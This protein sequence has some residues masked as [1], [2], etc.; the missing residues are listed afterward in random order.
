MLLLKDGFLIL[1]IGVLDYISVVNK[2]DGK[3]KIVFN[4]VGM[5][6]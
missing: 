4:G 6:S 5:F 3:L 1:K 2:I